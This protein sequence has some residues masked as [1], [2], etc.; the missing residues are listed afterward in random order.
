V[1]DGTSILFWKDYWQS[2]GLLCEKYPRLFSFVIEEDAT[3]VDLIN[4][5]MSENLF[6]LPLS[7][8]A[9]DE[10]QEI[11]NSFQTLQL[12]NTLLDSRTFSW[13]NAQYTSAKYYKFIFDAIP[14]DKTLTS[15]WKSKCLLKGSYERLEGG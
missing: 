11:Q 7:A 1:G 8:Q 3:V 14:E 2:E 6:A 15:I 5:N 9:Y 12:N 13:G 10:L 4:Q